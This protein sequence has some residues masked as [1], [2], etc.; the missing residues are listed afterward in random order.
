MTEALLKNTPNDNDD[1][2]TPNN[3]V[4]LH[5]PYT[6]VPMFWS[7]AGSVKVRAAIDGKLSSHSLWTYGDRSCIYVVA[8]MGYEGFG[9]WYNGQYLA[10]C[11][12]MG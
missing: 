12:R 11:G 6:H 10:Y 8:L 3:T 2:D 9:R 4:I 5:D 1:D 7:E